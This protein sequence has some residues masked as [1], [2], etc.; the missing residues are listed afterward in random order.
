M[1]QNVF[2]D[3]KISKR[4][5]ISLLFS[6]SFGIFMS[7]QKNK[8]KLC[9]SNFIHNLHVTSYKCKHVLFHLNMLKLFQKINIFF[10]L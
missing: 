2:M 6:I 4:K 8:N 10:F 5:Q 9:L 1:F 7:F 3:P